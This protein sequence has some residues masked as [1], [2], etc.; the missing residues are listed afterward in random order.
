VELP[1]SKVRIA[2]VPRLEGTDLVMWIQYKSEQPCHLSLLAVGNSSE[3]V[4]Q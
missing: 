3:Y 4:T 1:N 2:L